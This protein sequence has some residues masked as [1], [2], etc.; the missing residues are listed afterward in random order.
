MSTAIGPND[1]LVHCQ[2]W[3]LSGDIA[4]SN[5]Q[6]RDRKLAVRGGGCPGAKGYSAMFKQEANVIQAHAELLGEYRKIKN[7]E[8][9]F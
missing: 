4:G 3:H 6:Q 5:Q 7:K 2:P 1:H 8:F 9:S